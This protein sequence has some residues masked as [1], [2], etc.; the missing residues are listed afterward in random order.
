VQRVIA[1]AM[2]LGAVACG[3]APKAASDAAAISD[4]ISDDCE[5]ATVACDGPVVRTCGA[6]HHWDPSQDRTCE[7]TCSAGTC[8]AASNLPLDDVAMCTSAAA[9]LAPASGATV[10]V[11]E[12]GGTHLDCS[13]NCGVPG[14][15]R[16]DVEKSYAGAPGLALFCLAKLVLP[17]ATQLGIPSG[18]G[19]KPAIAFVVD[20]EVT[21]DGIVSFDGGSAGSGADGGH[22]GPGGYDGATKSSDDGNAGQ[23][24]CHGS[25]GTNDGPPIAS[26]FSGGGGGGAGNMTIGGDGGDG[27][28]VN[29]DHHGHG[30]AHGGVCGT[31]DLQPLIG[32]SGGGG[33]G[34]ATVDG[35]YGYAG[36]GGGGALQISARRTITITGSVSARGGAGYGTMSIDGGG[37]GGA[38]G[39]LLFEAPS[40]LISGALDVDGGS[41]GIAGPHLGGAGA[42]VN[43][44]A[45]SGVS[46]TGNGQGGTGGGGGGGRI[47]IVGGNATCVGGVS[48]INS[49]TTGV[50]PVV[51]P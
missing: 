41:G 44:L 50:L 24:P 12:V 27:S 3:F 4:T 20:G 49:C 45:A 29:G 2:T 47:R 36:G 22:A 30:G 39:G 46:Y 7:F 43:M 33:G 16:I 42:T 13:P 19:P 40:L 1:I 34:D 17:A 11:S 32:G 25:G 14:V 48:P 5:P 26:D 6:D 35:P 37:G 38:G 21:I 28:C 51:P 9:V 23:G 15:T 31:D 8:V 18:G 10:Y